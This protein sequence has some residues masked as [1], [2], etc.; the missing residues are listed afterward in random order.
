MK[1]RTIAAALIATSGLVVASPPAEAYTS[2]NWTSGFCASVGGTRGY[3]IPAKQATSTM[4]Y[5]N[6][7]GACY[8]APLAYCS[9]SSGD[10]R[11]YRGSGNTIAQGVSTYDCDSNSTYNFAL[12]NNGTITSTSDFSSGCQSNC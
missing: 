7:G 6:G 5:N 12:T 1:I 3:S 9:R 10:V 8:Q 2:S 4:T 11:V